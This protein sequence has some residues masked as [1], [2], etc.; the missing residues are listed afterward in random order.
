MSRKVNASPETLRKFGEDIRKF[1]QD[2]AELIRRIKADYTNAGSE[3][4]D[5]Q[6]QK[7]GQC[8][9]EIVTSINRLLPTCEETVAHLQKKANDLESYLN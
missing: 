2:E 6:Y 5:S 4:Q 7:F 3:W 9:E 8:I 1:A